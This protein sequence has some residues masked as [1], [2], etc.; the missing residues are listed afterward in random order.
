VHIFTADAQ[1]GYWRWIGKRS[2]RPMSSI[3]LEPAVKEM[4]LADCR[5]FL[6][7]EDWYAER[8]IPFRRG[9]LLHGV[10][11]SGKTSLIN[12]LAGE[13]DLDICV[14]NMSSQGMSDRTLMKLIKNVP[15]GCLLLFEDLD[16]A[17]TGGIT[18][19]ADPT[20]NANGGSDL[21][22]S[23][24]LTSLDFAEGRLVFVTTNH[25]ERL[26]PALSRPG[27]MDVS[28]NFTHATKWQAEWLF[29]RF[30]FPSRPSASSPNESPSLGA[31]R[32]DLS[33][34]GRGASA[35]AAAVL[36]EAEIVQLAQHFANAIPE[37][38]MSV[39]SLQGYLLKNKRRP[40][41]C[42][43]EVTEWVKQE[44]TARALGQE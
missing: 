5:D 3:V 32:E 43:G 40:R 38:E 24:L 41:E 28:V 17:I 13:L 30:F 10:P 9:Y 22:L 12:S 31:P 21:S 23:G 20:A 15:S 44:R 11:R 14:L 6:R 4:L 2:R 34:D 29:K 37:G 18:S 39:A 7:S 16:T 26:D 1:H 36:E 19:T 25:V 33:R 27:C 8:A 35:H 42:V